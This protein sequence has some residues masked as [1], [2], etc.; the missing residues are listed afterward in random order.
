MLSESDIEK[1]FP[2]WDAL[3][4]LFLDTELDETSHRYIARVI[5]E[6]GF[7]P[8]EIHHILWYEVFPS[9]GD[10]LR[11]VAGEWAGFNH[12]WLKSRILS[13]ISGEIASLTAGGIISVNALVGITQQEWSKVCN[14]LPNDCRAELM[15]KSTRFSHK[16]R[17][18]P[19]KWWVFWKIP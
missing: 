17:T 4:E 8:E 19:K 16:N 5:V 6:S 7:T 18:A 3:S 13:V 12:E 15:K 11:C 14:Y 10:N 9:V 2:V 1:R